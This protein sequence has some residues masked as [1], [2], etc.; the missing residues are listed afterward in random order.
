MMTERR[1]FWLHVKKSAGM[2]TRKLLQ[3]YY[4]EVDRS[5]KPKTFIQ[6]SPEEYNDI[7][8]NYRVVIGEY[9]FRRCLF[10]KTY[11]YPNDWDK[12][13]SFA[14][15]REPTDRCISMFF[16][17][18]YTEKMTV[19][20][21]LARLYRI[22]AK[23]KKIAYNKLYMFDIFL[24]YV[25]TARAN[26][27]IYKP[28]GLHFSTHTATMWDDITDNTGNILLTK[29]YRVENLE[30][31]INEVYEQCGINKKL[32]TGFEK[33]NKTKTRKDFSPSKKQLSVIHDIFKYDYDVYENAE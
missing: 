10:A 32:T 6:A 3:P 33:I 5:S 8:N 7:L 20:H 9:Q 12:L 15:S 18:F 21:R 30:K 14:F 19:F 26:K 16:Y 27:S 31:G 11:L 25:I 24:E 17:L 2:H 29:I 28:L 23:S 4:V 22:Y 1:F 13:F